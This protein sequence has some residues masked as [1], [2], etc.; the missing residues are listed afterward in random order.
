[1]FT[2]S[3]EDFLLF[4]KS[5]WWKHILPLTGPLADGGVCGK[6]PRA[7]LT[8]EQ[9]KGHKAIRAEKRAAQK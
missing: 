2:D 4:A 3:V 7:F 8:R 6:A 9:I 5:P 1:V